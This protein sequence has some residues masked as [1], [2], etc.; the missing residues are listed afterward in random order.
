MN[1]P[2]LQL[3]QLRVRLGARPLREVLA[4]DDLTVTAGETV[5]LLGPNGSGKSTLLRA[6]ALLLHPAEG[7][8]A[9]FGQV[10]R[11]RS[12]QVAVRRRTASVFSDATLLDMTVRANVETP[13]RLRGVPSAERA[14]RVDEWLA[15]VGVE[16]LAQARAYTLSAGEAQRVAL[17]RAFVTRPDLVFLDEPFAALDIETRARLVGELRDLLRQ[18]GAAALIATHDRTE[19]RL[20]AG[21]VLVLLDGRVE[22]AGAIEVLEAAP[23]SAR[24]AAFLGYSIVD[25]AALALAAGLT[26]QGPIA[27]LPRDGVT[28]APVGTSG[29]VLAPVLT[30][31]G[32]AGHVEVVCDLAGPVAVEGSA[33]ALP[34]IGET[35]AL[36]LDGSRIR[37]FRTRD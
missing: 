31:R 23:A 35:V 2:A 26:P 12:E 34:A 30:V 29:A 25:G 16:H 3:Q 33:S 6:A 32:A 36:Q 10:P 11:T 27:A 21:R 17:A 20:L 5:A 15:R 28:V 1:A 4:V 37:W 8:V 9:L 14:A 24:V 18:Q 13:L 19:A 7:S 22:Q